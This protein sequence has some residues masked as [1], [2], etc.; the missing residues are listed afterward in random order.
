V[1]DADDALRRVEELHERLIAAREELDKAAE[2]ED[3]DAAVDILT[4]L[5]E[6][7]KEVE[8]ELQKARARADAAG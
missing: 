3:P 2:R 5:A 8:A 1:S 6:L 4:Q 7:A